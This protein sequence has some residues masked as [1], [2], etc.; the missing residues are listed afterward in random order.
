[1]SKRI[2]VENLPAGATSA[3]VKDL[4]VP[5]GR[6]TSVTIDRTTAYVEMDTEDQAR[7][8]LSNLQNARLGTNSLNVNEARPR[9]APRLS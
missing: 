2:Y 8:A 4:F 7:D 9:R 3:E 5:F 6:V 1:M